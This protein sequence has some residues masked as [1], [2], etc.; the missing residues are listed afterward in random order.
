M[1]AAREQPYGPRTAQVRSFLK[2]LS[3]LPGVAWMAAARHYEAQSVTPSARRADRALAG[4]F[5]RANRLHV[6]DALIG[7]VVQLTRKGA[8]LPD[9]DDDTLE[10]VAE[11]ALAAT[12]AVAL[13]DVLD[14]ADRTALYAPF[15]QAIPADSL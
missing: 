10:R 4:A 11:A 7:P 1:I 5:A 3:Q 15:A 6:R 2:R 8:L 9:D 14:D 12:Y 13:A